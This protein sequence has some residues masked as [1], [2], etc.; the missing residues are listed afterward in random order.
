MKL[1]KFFG[2][3]VL[4]SSIALAGCGGDKKAEQAAAPADT[5]QVAQTIKV[6]VMSGPEHAVAEVAAKV[7]KE[8]M[9]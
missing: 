2:L 1:N 9:V 6:G 3:C 5:D 8:N 7:A 4:A